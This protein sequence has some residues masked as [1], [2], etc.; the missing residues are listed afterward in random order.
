[1]RKLISCLLFGFLISSVFAQPLL[2]DEQNTIK[3]FHRMSP[4]VVNVHQVTDVP[5]NFWH[6]QQV[7]TGSGSGLI[8]NKQGYIITNFHVV[9]GAHQL[10]VTFHNRQSVA[11]HIVGVDR[12]NDIEFL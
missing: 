7:A 10:A 5:V 8:W 1:M 9:E 11:A 4:F 12:Q 2:P 6:S 3:L